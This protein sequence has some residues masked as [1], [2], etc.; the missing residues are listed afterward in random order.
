ML[1]QNQFKNQL[2]H[3][4]HQ[5]LAE[6]LKELINEKDPSI[7]WSLVRF[8]IDIKL[9]KTQLETDDAPTDARIRAA[10]K[11]VRGERR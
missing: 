5:A 11:E 8:V 6:K 10:L 7:D 3:A 2:L 9:N 1:N 4:S